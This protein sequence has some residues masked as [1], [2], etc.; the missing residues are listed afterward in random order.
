MEENKNLSEE[1]LAEREAELYRSDEELNQRER[2]L[3][4][5]DE[6]V[7]GAKENLYSHINVSLK[8]MNIVVAVLAVILVVCIVVGIITR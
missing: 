8:T 7:I 6:K 5:L 3:S 4:T 1:Q 2:K